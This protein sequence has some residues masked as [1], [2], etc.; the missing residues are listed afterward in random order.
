MTVVRS[1]RM[2]LLVRE[3]ATARCFPLFRFHFCNE[4]CVEHVLNY[5]VRSIKM[6]TS[7]V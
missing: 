4:H 5:N 7:I 2:D 6:E 3:L 1:W